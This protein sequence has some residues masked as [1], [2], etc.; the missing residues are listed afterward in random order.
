MLANTI[1]R[2]VAIIILLCVAGCASQSQHP[3]KVE[4]VQ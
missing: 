4:Y 1:L 3:P 2:V